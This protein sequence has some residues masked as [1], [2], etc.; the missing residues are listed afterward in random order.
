[1]YCTN[2]MISHNYDYALCTKAVYVIVI[3]I[4]FSPVQSSVQD[5]EII[6]YMCILR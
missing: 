4:T 2:I 3:M 5:I 1:M 6:R